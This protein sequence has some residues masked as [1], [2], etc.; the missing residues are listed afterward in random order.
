MKN[1]K[2][3]LAAVIAG[4]V[5]AVC[6]PWTVSAAEAGDTGTYGDLTY[7]VLEDGTIEITDC[8]EAATE[9]E[10]PAE[11]DGMA[12]ASIG[13]EAFWYCEILIDISI[14]DSV[15]TIGR[16]AFAHCTG[17]T[18]ISLS[19][20]VTEIEMGAFNCCS[21]L[22]AIDIPDSVIN[23][24]LAS[25]FVECSSLTSIDIPDC[26]T[27]IGHV[28]FSGCTSLAYVTIPNSVESI[29]SYSFYNCTSLTDIYYAGAEAEWNAIS[30]DNTDGC[31]DPLTNATIH[32]NGAASEITPSAGDIDGDNIIDANDAYI[33]LLAYAKLS[34]GSDS[35]LNDAQI[36][37]ADVDGDGSITA[38]DAYYIL[39]YYAKRSVGQDVSW[40][41]L[42][43]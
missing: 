41:E 2:N 24:D 34:V 7:T 17:L 27:N 36:E 10:I 23:F 19:E 18:S 21:N 13:D 20:N 1:F 37:A 5:C 33:S 14:P 15:I 40:A 32:F 43:G 22:T 38:N 12:V 28:A 8:D 39:L 9:V 30:I 11:I 16:Y 35:G 31:N 3:I 26:V 4:V 29:D 25:T 42:L 6:V